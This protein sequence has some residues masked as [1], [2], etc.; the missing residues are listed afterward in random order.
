M[1]IL[2]QK[3]ANAILCGSMDNR[4]H[5]SAFSGEQGISNTLAL[6]GCAAHDHAAP[7]SATRKEHCID[8]SMV[9]PACITVHS[10]GPANFGY[11]G[12]HSFEYV[13]S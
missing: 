4:I 3:L 1:L 11:H 12:N 13:V 5:H 7:C 10:R 2:E 6:V 9:I 8:A